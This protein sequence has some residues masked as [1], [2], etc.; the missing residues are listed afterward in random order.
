DEAAARR[1]VSDLLS[2][3]IELHH[4]S[5]VPVGIFLSG[6]IDSS[7]LVSLTREIGAV[8]H[9]F[10]VVLPGSMHDEAKFARQVAHAFGAE[11]TE[12]PLTDQDF[13]DQLPEATQSVDHPSGDGLNTFVVSRAVRMAGLKVA[14]SGL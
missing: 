9:T 10:S 5:D 4:V 7:A 11:H 14:L 13:R 2:K 3:S 6:G 1:R 12:I 8:P